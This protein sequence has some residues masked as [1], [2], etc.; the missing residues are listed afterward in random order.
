MKVLIIGAGQAG[1]TTAKTL[2]QLDPETDIT[3]FDSETT[4]L[5]AKMRLPEL[6]AG[7][8]AEEKLFLAK[9]E[10][11]HNLGIKTEFGI[12]VSAID[13]AA[14][15]VKTE[16]GREFS[17]DKLI[18][19]CGAMAFVPPVKGSESIISCVLRT[20]N[21]ARKISCSC[22]NDAEALV[23]GGGLLGLEAAWALRQRGFTVT[24]S[25]FMNRLLPKQLNDAE[26]ALL[27]KKLQSPGLQIRLNS[28]LEEVSRKEDGKINARF[29][30]GTILTCDL[31]LFS[32]GIRSNI[33]LA[34]K[35]GLQTERGIVVD[36]RL[37]TSDP[38]IFAVGDCAELDGKTPGLWLAAKDQ[39]T[40]VA[41]II[42]GKRDSFVSPVYTPNLKI[43]GI[44][45]KEIKQEAAAEKA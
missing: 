15:C 23:I 40:A 2:K 37:C 43:A 35:A 3:V 25:E 5:Y 14:H 32:A 45:L 30:D 36:S 9:P 6:V 12:R 27:L 7:T 39:G 26:S 16:D 34:Q 42:A 13:P 31:L 11:L 22:G 44:Q 17:Y 19:A 18:L 41:E 21:D 20:L 38:D 28:T 8:L 29:S 1:I 10:A 4:G 33:S 24:V